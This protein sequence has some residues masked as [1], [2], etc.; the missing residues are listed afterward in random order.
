MNWGAES[1]AVH[2]RDF[3]FEFERDYG[4]IGGVYWNPSIDVSFH[5]YKKSFF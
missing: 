4:D 5:A 3:G 2:S 1:I